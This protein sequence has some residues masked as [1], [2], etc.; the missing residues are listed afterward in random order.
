MT[1]YLIHFS[2]YT[3][4]MIGI[5]FGALYVFKLCAK[6]SFSK[7]SQ[8][9]N[10]EDTMAL[11]ARKKLHVINVDGE[12]FLIAADMDRTSL[13]SKLGEKSVIEKVT[14]PTPIR[15][16]KSKTLK[17]FDGIESLSEFASIID[18]NKKN[19]NINKKPMMKELARKLNAI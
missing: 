14:P 3:L 4:A 2:I 13:I 11:S 18:F 12:R 10:I 8:M 7:K 17:S 1:G 16:D 9:L 19:S 5:I 6:A 15:E